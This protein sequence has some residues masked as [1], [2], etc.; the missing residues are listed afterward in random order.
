MHISKGLYRLWQLVSHL[1]L[2]MHLHMK[3][4]F[5]LNLRLPLDFA[6]VNA[7]EKELVERRH[8]AQLVDRRRDNLDGVVC[9]DVDDVTPREKRAR[10]TH[11]SR[12]SS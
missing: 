3:L 1:V 8:G 10:Q 5:D 4:R 9:D 12:R 2:H 11:R 7:I 6:N